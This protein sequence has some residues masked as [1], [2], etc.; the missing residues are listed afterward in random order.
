MSHALARLEKLS[1]P[2]IAPFV[3]EPALQGRKSGG[4][5]PKEPQL[6]NLSLEL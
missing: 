2:A 5:R 1:K 4:Q 3:I 6:L